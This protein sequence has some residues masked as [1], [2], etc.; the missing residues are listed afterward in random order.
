[1]A[2]CFRR[3]IR[4]REY[5]FSAKIALQ[6]N[7]N[8]RFWFNAVE[9]RSRIDEPQSAISASAAAPGI[10]CTA[11]MASSPRSGLRTP[12]TAASATLGWVIRRLWHA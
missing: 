6:Q 5:R 9:A 7:K 4:T 1:M 2:C 3:M 11:A 8:T 10:A 12:N